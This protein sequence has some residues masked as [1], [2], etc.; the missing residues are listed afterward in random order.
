MES[1]HIQSGKK[2]VFRGICWTEV[3]GRRR[4]QPAP[5]PG[6]PSSKRSVIGS[7]APGAQVDRAQRQT[8]EV[9]SPYLRRGH[10]AR[11]NPAG[12]GRTARGS[13]YVLT[14]HFPRAPSASR[15]L[16]GGLHRYRGQP[17]GRD[18]RFPRRTSCNTA[19]VSCVR[20]GEVEVR[21]ERQTVVK[22]TTSYKIQQ[23]ILLVNTGSRKYYGQLNITR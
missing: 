23:I 21:R 10:A 12:H 4:D 22:S 7:L 9:G 6:A 18:P 13:R 8:E 19:G 15:S 16:P 11:T 14:G 1:P 17:V 3:R 20:V 2:L 5:G